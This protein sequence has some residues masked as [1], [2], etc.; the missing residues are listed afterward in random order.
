MASLN[1]SFDEV[2]DIEAPLPL[3][4]D[5]L[6]EWATPLSYSRRVLYSGVLCSPFLSTR[7]VCTPAWG[8]L[9]FM[10]CFGLKEGRRTKPV[11]YSLDS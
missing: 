3:L 7:V 8:S 5:G 4:I 10:V 2:A 1:E 11:G 9:A 6:D